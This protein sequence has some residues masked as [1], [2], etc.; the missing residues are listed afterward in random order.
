MAGGIAATLLSATRPH[1]G[2]A[3]EL[4][5]FEVDE[6][7]LDGVA[8]QLHPRVVLLGN[9]FRDQLDRYGELEAIA[10]SWE[11]LLDDGGLAAVAGGLPPAGLATL[12][13]NAD[14]PLIADLG[15]E[16]AGVLYFGVQDDSLALPGM[17]HAADA[18]HCRRCGAPYVFEA[19]Y[20]GHLGHYR[21]ASCG[22]RRPAARGDRYKRCPRR[23]ARRAL[24][25][26]HARR[27]GRGR[28]AGCP[29]S[30]TSTTR[31]PPPRSRQRSGS[32][33]RRIVAGLERTRGRVR[34]GR[35]GD[36][37]APGTTAARVRASR[38]E[39]AD[40]ADQEPGRRQRGAAHARDR[41][42]RARPARGA[43]R[44]HRRRARRLLDL[45]RGLRA[46]ARAGAP[47]HLQRQ[48]RT[49]ARG[50]AE[51]R[52]ASSPRGSRVQP[53]LQLALERGR[54]ATV[55]PRGRRCTRCRPTPRCSR[56]ASCS[57]RA[58]RRATHGRELERG[59][60][61]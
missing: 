15:R 33:S 47:R 36:A 5:L 51:V 18:K 60:L 17:A 34:P 49:R 6:L 4:G 32:T 53:D 22:R 21:C 44:Q 19:I 61:A 10:E 27:R 7:W 38:R 40:P 14:D 25:A 24:H 8:A 11:R 54:R 50:A 39:L 31:S 41:A 46:P 43:Q 58:G 3:G 2:M 59:R 28:A 45:G 35:D 55:P 42:R 1:G 57:S 13:L 56:C 52:R 30:T 29:A 26:A 16:R 9:L 23:R 37:V 48:P 12:V 20:L